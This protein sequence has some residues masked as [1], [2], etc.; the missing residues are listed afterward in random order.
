MVN[1]ARWLDVDPESSLRG[2]NLR[3]QL[4][5]EA[6][7]VLAQAEGRRLRDMSLEDLDRLWRHVKRQE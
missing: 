1:V 6:M 5:F 4:R 7:S 2:A 3:F